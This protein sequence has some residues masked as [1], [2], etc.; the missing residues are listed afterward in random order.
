MS[1]NI[2]IMGRLHE[3][4]IIEIRVQDESKAA[5]EQITAIAYELKNACAKLEKINLSQEQEQA[6]A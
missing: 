3:N 5:L 2:E 6:T 1:Y 4:P